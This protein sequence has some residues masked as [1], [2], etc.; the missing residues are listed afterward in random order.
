MVWFML[1]LNFIYDMYMMSTFQC[2]I[3]ML[4]SKIDMLIN[5]VIV[6]PVITK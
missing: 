5:I 3:S 4:S 2:N 6:I 1:F